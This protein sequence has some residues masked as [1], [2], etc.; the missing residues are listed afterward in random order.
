LSDSRLHWN[1]E[2]YAFLLQQVRK[3]QGMIN[4]WAG[5]LTL[6]QP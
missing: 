5:K 4:A 3:T 1:D 2:L 6:P